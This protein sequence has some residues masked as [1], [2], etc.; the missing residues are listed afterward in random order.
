VESGFRASLQNAQ[1][2]VSGSQSLISTGLHAQGLS[3]AVLALEELGKLYAIDGLLFAR[4]DDHKAAVFEK[5]ERSH[6]IKLDILATLPLLIGHLAEA[7]PRYGTEEAYNRA[8]AVSM[9]ELQRDVITVLSM[10]RTRSFAELDIWKQRGFYT[11]VS[12]TGFRAPRDA[13][14]AAFATVIYH[15]AWRAT[16]TLDF[17]LKGGNL[18]RYITRARSIRA[19]LSDEEHQELEG[20]PGAIPRALPT[21][22]ASNRG[23]DQLNHPGKRRKFNRGDMRREEGGFNLNGGRGNH[24]QGE[25]PYPSRT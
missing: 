1:D 2:L 24:D 21:A 3:L 14:N 11:E 23:T 7:D 13:I 9:V 17:I 6:A 12:N 8:L 20:W 15:L 10:L 5:S 19:A 18:D 25:N 22:R 4:A 16:T